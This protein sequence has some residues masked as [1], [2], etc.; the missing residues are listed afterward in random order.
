MSSANVGGL[1]G[2][3]PPPPPF[4]HTFT[5]FPA[6]YLQAFFSITSTAPTAGHSSPQPQL[7][8]PLAISQAVQAAATPLHG[9]WGGGVPFDVVDVRWVRGPPGG[10]VGGASSV[11]ALF[12]V[13]SDNVDILSTT[14]LATDSNFWARTLFSASPTSSSNTNGPNPA[15][16]FMVRCSVANASPSLPRCLSH[17]NA[18]MK[19]IL[20]H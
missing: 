10:S 7:P 19:D 5:S 15:A 18:W 13:E 3:L 20:H 12:R 4:R 6:V 14:L 11:Q 9:I 16:A 17:S 8:S 2:P 1:T